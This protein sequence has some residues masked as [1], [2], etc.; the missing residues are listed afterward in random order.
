MSKTY[1]TTEDRDAARA[2]VAE[3]L[4]S[5]L[6]ISEGQTSSSLSFGQPLTAVN[7]TSLFRGAI[8]KSASIANPWAD[9]VPISQAD[10]RLGFKPANE[11]IGATIEEYRAY[12]LVDHELRLRHPYTRKLVEARFG[13]DVRFSPLDLHE[14]DDEVILILRGE[15]IAGPEYDEDVT[16]G[17]DLLTCSESET[18]S[19]SGD[20]NRRMDTSSQSLG[21]LLI[22]ESSLSPQPDSP[23]NQ[24]E[25][26]KM[27][28]QRQLAL[29]AVDKFWI[30]A[31]KDSRAKLKK[32]IKN[33]AGLAAAR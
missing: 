19:E 26:V 20:E 23:I 8:S 1:A 9:R 4:K 33:P 3:E 29:E 12:A 6:I 17:G 13:S 15:K 31:G 27:Q 14:R 18:S 25:F 7:K 16:M 32:G 21:G 22:D 24:P 10:L 30:R 2:R 11:R 5:S 28:R